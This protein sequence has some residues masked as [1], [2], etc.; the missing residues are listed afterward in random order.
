MLPYRDSKI[1]RTVLI[2]FFILVI[3]YSYYEA[4]G[5]LFGPRIEVPQGTAVVH[6]RFIT[7]NGKAESIAELTMNG[8]PVTVTEDG[9][10]GEPYLL[11]DGYNRIVLRA[12]DKYGRASEKVVEVIYEPTTVIEILTATSSPTST[13]TV[14]Q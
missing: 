9:A 11:S 10:F 5:R 14:A 2:L 12:R 1:I 13:S 6:E 4:R 7:I 3:F 8:K